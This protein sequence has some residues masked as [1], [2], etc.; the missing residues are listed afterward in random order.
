MWY[1]FG[2]EE[3]YRDDLRK[4]LSAV[5][6]K[7][8]TFL[9]KRQEVVRARMR[10][11]QRCIRLEA[12]GPI[13]SSLTHLVNIYRTIVQQE[14]TIRAYDE[15]I[16][17][18]WKVVAYLKELIRSAPK[19]PRRP[20]SSIAASGAKAMGITAQRS[21]DQDEKMALLAWEAGRMAAAETAKCEVQNLPLRSVELLERRWSE[22]YPDLQLTIRRG[23]YHVAPAAVKGSICK[24]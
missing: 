16:A 13:P 7:L 17:E 11:R 24:K 18:G 14:Q 1:V 15:K 2:M 22:L 3:H 12:D 4:K 8:K 19:R 10:C 9:K 5:E 6:K 20:E 21:T 23:S